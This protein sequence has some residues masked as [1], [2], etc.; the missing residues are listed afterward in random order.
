MLGRARK[1]TALLLNGAQ[2]DFTLTISFPTCGDFSPDSD[3][4]LRTQVVSLPYL[5]LA[6]PSDPKESLLGLS[7]RVTALLRLPPRH[8]GANTHSPGRRV[9][10]TV[11]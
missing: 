4:W 9:G 1:V 11:K 8:S 2:G 6:G 7:Y 10:Y 3:T 5:T